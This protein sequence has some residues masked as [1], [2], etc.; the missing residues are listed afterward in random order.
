MFRGTLFVAVCL[1]AY[2]GQAAEK[3]TWQ[4]QLNPG[5]VFHVE[6]HQRVSSTNSLSN[7]VAQALGGRALPDTHDLAF[8]FSWKV[9]E[10]TDPSPENYRLDNKIEL[11]QTLKRVIFN[12][13]FG[14]VLSKRQCRWTF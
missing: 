7:G 1:F 8:V 9:A 11:T 10:A 4:W 14:G 13:Q 3:R 5:D 2:S 12:C 6:F